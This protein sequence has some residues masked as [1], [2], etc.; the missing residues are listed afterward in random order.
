MTA[1]NATLS[2]DR[3]VSWLL[4]TDAFGHDWVKVRLSR[5][6][7]Y[8]GALLAAME[9]PGPVLQAGAA[10]C[11]APFAASDIE[12]ID[13]RYRQRDNEGR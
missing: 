7:G 13:R 1:Y 12:Q 6:P 11:F 9:G 3:R 2:V 5:P 10:P 8:P 4:V